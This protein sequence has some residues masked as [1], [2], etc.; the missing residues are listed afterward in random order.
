MTQK[1][2]KD[3]II[4][5]LSTLNIRIYDETVK[6]GFKE[7]CFFVKFLVNT[8]EKIKTNRYIRYNTLE[9]LYFSDK[10]DSKQDYDEMSEKL[11]D[12][13]EYIYIESEE[14]N[15][16]A[17][18]EIT[19]EVKDDVLHISVDYNYHLVTLDDKK[20]MKNL[21]QGVDINE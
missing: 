15:I 9:L 8:H 16:R 2:L 5:K 20:K 18:G 14:I 17:S 3:G 12:L 7:P 11:N 6:Q 1:N 19:S 21:E 10:E 4:S 13:L